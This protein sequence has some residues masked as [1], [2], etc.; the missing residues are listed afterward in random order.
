MLQIC[1]V[2]P[3]VAI[4]VEG[5]PFT[6]KAPFP[7]DRVLGILRERVLPKYV[8]LYEQVEDHRG[9]D[10][11]SDIDEWIEEMLRAMYKRMIKHLKPIFEENGALVK[12]V[13]FDW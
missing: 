12:K 7:S 11:S 3:S 13:A 9:P 5:G 10:G 6:A 4:R 2:A 8:S 1:V